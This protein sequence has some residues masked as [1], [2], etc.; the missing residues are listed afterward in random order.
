[1]DPHSRFSPFN[2]RQTKAGPVP[3]ST[4]SMEQSLKTT[5]PLETY[6]KRNT[7]QRRGSASSVT[8]LTGSR[9]IATNSRVKQDEQYR[10]DMYLAFINN[11]LQQKLKGITDAFDELVDQFNSK[12]FSG[13]TPTSPAQLRI[14]LTALSHVVSR[15]ERAHAP[16]LEAIVGMPWTTMDLAFVKS[17]VS[18]I[19]MLVSAKPEYLNMVLGM[20]ASGL[21]YQSGLQA[22]NVGIPESSSSPLTRR[23]VYNRIHYLSQHLLSLVPTLPST[24]QPLLVR[25]FPHKRQ[26]QASQVTYIRNLLRITEYCPELSDRIF[27]TIVDRAI[28]IDVEI[29]VELEELEEQAGEDQ[30]EIFDLDPFDTVVG[31]EGESDSE[32]GSDI[33][34]AFSD[35]SSEADGEL[36]DSDDPQPEELTNFQHVQD[37]VNKLDAIL[38]NVFDHFAHIRVPSE[39]PLQTPSTPTLQ[40]TLDSSSFVSLSNPLMLPTEAET[41]AIH[42]TQFYTLLSIFDRTILRT[43]KSRYTQFLIFWYSSLDPEF[44]DLFQGMLVSKALLEEDQPAVTRAAAASY[45]ASFVSRA[46][47]VGRESTRQAVACLCNFLANRLSI[48]DAVT[49]SGAQPPSLSQHTVF[50]AVTQAVFLIFCFRW[51]DLQHEPED[52]DELGSVTVPAS[53]WMPELS[54]LKKVVQSELNPLKVCASNVVMQ[55]ARVAHATD[56]LYCYSIIEANRR[57]DFSSR[58]SSNGSMPTLPRSNSSFISPALLGHTMHSELNTFFPFDPYRLPRSGSYIQGVYREWSSVAIDDEED[59]DSDSDNEDEGEGIEDMSSATSHEVEKSEPLLVGIPIGTPHLE[60]EDSTDGLGAS[61]GG[62]SISPA[63]PTLS[64]SVGIPMSVS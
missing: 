39:L 55:F 24:L 7:T 25:N 35:L 49:Q 47:F 64:I 5:N 53:K 62:M 20:V 48:L 57:M 13:E 38:K 34:D 58:S 3:S 30:T 12:Q 44:S 15:L 21:T 63:Q 14:W 46:E 36:D 59:S 27:A 51:R 4:R 31:Q 26:N 22:L 45:I 2:S 37:M 1:M 56:F 28:Q 60:T 16:L 19:G 18:F 8:S 29:Q 17:Y 41:K 33:G 32:D 61:F 6:K 10:K 9:P 50:Y 23:I 43:F 40:S 52:T 42:R 54:V 11:A